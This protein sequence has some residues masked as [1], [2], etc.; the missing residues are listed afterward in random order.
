MKALISLFI[1]LF[2][3]QAQ[4]TLPDLTGNYTGCGMLSSLGKEQAVLVLV[5]IATGFG[6]DEFRYGG[7]FYWKTPNAQTSVDFFADVKVDDPSRRILMNTQIT[8]LHDFGIL[9]RAVDAQVNADGSITGKFL[10]NS[11]GS[12][13][14]FQIGNFTVTRVDGQIPTLN[15]R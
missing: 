8:P 6:P 13:G 1:T 5:K 3:L 9:L 7:G 12:D 11:T 14:R 4:A 10:T 2:A 15:C